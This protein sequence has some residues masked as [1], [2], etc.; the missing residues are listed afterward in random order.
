MAETIREA[1]R[2]RNPKSASLFPRFKSTFPSGVS[3]DMR[4][5][6]PFPLAIA[7]GQGSHKW[8][9]DG[10]AY[11][12]F[13]L[14]SA[15]LL[16]GHAHPS[17]V[18]ALVQ[19]APQGSHFGQSIEAELAWGE[20]VCKLIPCADKVRF[21]GS[22]AEATMLA[23]RIARGYTGK[24]KIIRWESHYHG[25][26]DYVMPGTLPP[27][28][29]PASI[30]IPQGAL[31]SVVVLPPD[32]EALERILAN[33]QDIAGVITEGSGASYGT[34]PLT[35]GFLQGVRELTQQYGVVMILDEVIT[36]FRWSPGGLQKKLGL[37]PDLC[38]LAKILT[39]GLP[40]G[41]VAGRDEFMQVMVQT[42]D[43]EH[44]RFQRVAHGGTFNAN[45]YCAATGNAA[46]SIVETGEMQAQADRMAARLRHG[47]QEC[48]DRHEVSA[49][50]YG[51]ASTFHVH[52]GNRSIEGLDAGTL[53]N[54][55]AA[56]QGHFRQALQNHGVDLM[57]RTSG[58]LSGVHSE[59]DIDAS[60]EGFDAA[61]KAMM[62]E[63]IIR[64]EA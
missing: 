15:S 39:G 57:S 34:V 27:F 33:E 10:N 31:D 41:A 19:A 44:D 58:V 59:A 42:G 16:L 36:G 64:P 8:D 60:L 56:I 7:R 2:R 49:C 21:V 6:E 11:I 25:W 22:G 32:L 24:D 23:M 45:P 30:G 28:D 55:P 46:L 38:S 9:V 53:K 62:R 14:G 47:L 20:Q 18:E 54:V 52:F 35:P 17:V 43:A 50:V 13:G 29:R 63:D 61:I 12:D 5:T 51:D 1:Y 48:F 40:G 4:A 3:H 37:M 26:H